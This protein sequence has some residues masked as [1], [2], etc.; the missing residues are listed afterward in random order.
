MAKI[1]LERFVGYLLEHPSR[2]IESLGSII[3]RALKDQG[4]IYTDG[5]IVTVC[6]DAEEPGA[7]ETARILSWSEYSALAARQVAEECKDGEKDWTEWID[8]MFWLQHP[9]LRDRLEGNDK[10]LESIQVGD[11]VT[12]NQ[13]GILVNL[14]QLKRVAKT[15]DKVGRKFKV[16]D[17]V[18]NDYCAG[19]VTELTDDAYLLDTGQGIP[20]SCEHNARLWTV[21]DAKPG[22]VLV[23][24]K[25][26]MP[27]IFKS[28]K[29]NHV[30]CFCAYTNHKDLFFPEFVNDDGGDLHW[31]NLLH[32]QVFPATKD[33]RNHL[34]QKMKDAGYEWDA[35][36]LELKKIGQKS[37]GWRDEDAA[38]YNRIIRELNT[39][40]EMPI[41]AHCVEYIKSDIDWLKSL[42]P[43][44]KPSEEQI[45]ALR[46]IVEGLGNN[47]PLHLIE[48]LKQLEKVEEIM[49][50]GLF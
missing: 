50:K 7:D 30:Y 14:S 38:H 17:F 23:N 33:Q 44:W 3:R 29:D 19:K 26:E 11:K 20:F 47:Y 22:D 48:L 9:E 6:S 43:Q 8:R 37:A 12:R 41:N 49:K 15:A 18:V 4:F 45:V 28:Y 46:C 5:K 40:K 27:F 13:D 35:N 21:K 24:Q 31:I 42:R 25:G 10:F 32:E 16:D 2:P 34:F 36:K 39:Q 1:D